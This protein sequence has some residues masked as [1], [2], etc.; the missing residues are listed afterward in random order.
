MKPGSHAGEAVNSL[1]VAT[2]AECSITLAL[3]ARLLSAVNEP[4]LKSVW[5]SRHSSF[6]RWNAPGVHTKSKA[7]DELYISGT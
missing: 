7:V 3:F 5:E 6:G 4:E 2:V 1:L